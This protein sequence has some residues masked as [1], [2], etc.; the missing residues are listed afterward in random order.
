MVLGML[1]F[2]GPSLAQHLVWKDQDVIR[3]LKILADSG[4]S[5]VR[6]R[7]NQQIE[8][9]LTLS[10]A[11]FIN[12]DHDLNANQVMV[13]Q[14]M[15]YQCKGE[16]KRRF[17]F[18]QKIVHHLGIQYFFDSIARFHVDDNQFETRLE[19]RIR[20]N[21]GCFISS[22][23]STRLFK[24]Y[25]FSANEQGYLVRTLNSSFLTPLTSLFSSGFQLKWPLFGSLNFGIT[26]AKLTWIRDK[27]IYEAQRTTIV[28]GV[29]EEKS[30]LFEYGISLQLL[31]DHD[32]AKWL[33]W[34]CDFL[35]FKNTNLSPDISFRNNLGFK[36][37]KFLKAR[38]Q[39]RI[40]YKERISKKVQLEN[41]VSVGFVVTL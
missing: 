13:I 25:S 7:I 9:S 31:I 30:H 18:T 10:N 33:H 14:D 16:T 12:W 8:Y 39:T 6:L 37:A 34:N 29:P 1:V 26:S 24:G 23:L 17:R 4:Q 15:V 32:V 19:W 22:I 36:L 28:Y 40:F 20:K 41:I 27:G 11:L 5:L 38:I 2:Q 3:N 35:I 21:H